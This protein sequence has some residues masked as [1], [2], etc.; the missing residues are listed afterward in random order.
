MLLVV[1]A[2]AALMT[3]CFGGG[4]D[5][6]RL[7]LDGSAAGDGVELEGVD[8]DVVVTSNHVVPTDSLTAD[9]KAGSCLRER[10]S[11][12][13]AAAEAVVRT[14]VSTESVTFL[15]L[16]GG[17][18]F[19]CS[20]SP[21]PREKGRWCGS[22]YGQLRAGKLDDPRLDIVCRGRDG[23]PTGFVWV[24]PGVGTQYVAVEQPDYT[25]VYEVA[26]GLP[27]RIATVSG[28]DVE[29]SSATFEISQYDADGRRLREQTL[30]AFVAG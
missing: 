10:F 26:G 5:E 6:S 16:G 11:D 19:G 17:T 28:V 2:A 21:G 18:V 1:L 8:G 25:E 3:G 9:S 24:E 29:T 4:D 15:E 13:R 27:I 14:G 7:L 30:E 12:L 20:N 23:T 22:S